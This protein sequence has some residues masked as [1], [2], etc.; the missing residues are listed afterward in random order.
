MNKVVA[1]LCRAVRVKLKD[2]N[3]YLLLGGVV[4]GWR[5]QYA[6]GKINRLAGCDCSGFESTK[7]SRN[8]VITPDQ[9]D[10]SIPGGAPRIWRSGSRRIY[11]NYRIAAHAATSYYQSVACGGRDYGKAIL[12]GGPPSP[13]IG[14][15]PI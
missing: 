13:S 11:A 1:T 15:I 2:L 8:K 9:I 5:R 12:R 10:Q 14:T 6:L 7:R 3:F 4:G